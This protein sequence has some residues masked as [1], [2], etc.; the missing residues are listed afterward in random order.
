MAKINQKDLKK[1]GVPQIAHQSIRAG[2]LG[3]ITG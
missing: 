1:M 2:D 3:V